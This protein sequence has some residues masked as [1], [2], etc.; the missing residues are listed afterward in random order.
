MMGRRMRT[1]MKQTR[2]R[3]ARVPQEEHSDAVQLESG[4]PSA[5]VRKTSVIEQTVASRCER[6]PEPADNR[7]AEDA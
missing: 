2:R 1:R 4:L 5:S 6:K 3:S 7:I